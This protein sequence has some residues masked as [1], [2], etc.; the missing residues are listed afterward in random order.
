VNLRPTVRFCSACGH[1]IARRVPPGDSRERD[2]C[3]ACGAIHYV[4]P[5]MIVGTIPVIDERVL[6]CLRAIEPRY[7]SWTL[8]AGFLEMGETAAQG[9]QRETDEEAGA[10][11]ELGPIFSMIDVPTVDQVHVFYRARLLNE[12]FAPGEESLQV[13][14]FREDEIPWDEIAFRTVSTTLQ[15]YFADR[16]RGHFEMHT[17]ELLPRPLPVRE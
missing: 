2:C 4:N 12:H 17:H 3:D 11:I 7:G 5:R 6:L 15:L 13:R 9:A 1:P 10:Q 14:L 16:A 8:P